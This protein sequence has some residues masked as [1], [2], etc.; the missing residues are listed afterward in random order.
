VG[1]GDT[2][3]I[4]D[5]VEHRF[6]R[7]ISQIQKEISETSLTTM[8]TTLPTYIALYHSGELAQRVQ[9]LEARLASCDICPRKCGVNRLRNETGFCH[10]G[11]LPMISSVCAHRGEEPAISGING[12]GTIFF[13]N[14]N[15]KCVYCQNYQ[16]SQDWQKQQSHET[17]PHSLAQK[18]LSLQND[19]GCHNINFVSPSH[20]VP[21]LARA[22]L[23]AV[24]LG[25][26]IPLIYNTNSYDSVD[27]LKELDGIIDIYLPD[28][29]YASDRIARKYSQ[30]PNY[31][32]VSRAAIRE[33]Y[34]QVQDLAVN[35]QGIA[36][37]GLIV[38]H[39]ILPHGL[40]DSEQSLKWLA[41]ELSTSVT[42][43]IMSQYLPVHKSPRVPLLSRV[44][45]TDEYELVRELLFDLKLENGWIQELGASTT[46]VPD[47]E[48]EGH[49]FS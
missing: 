46:Y 32:A 48:K 34:R 26:H 11:K 9:N 1:V 27:S 42:I 21:Q 45:S 24:P 44:I 35:N 33:M 29:K 3:H 31:V 30:A 43:S 7:I 10:S 4:F 5:S 23:E 20:F 37:R 36:Q 14:C 8:T 47:F 18:M 6:S 16:I 28:I 39:L 40:A 41:D 25:L 22:V 2:G 49:P 15:L 19:L 17:N 38:R 13:G 12:S